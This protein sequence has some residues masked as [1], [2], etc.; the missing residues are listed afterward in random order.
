MH[1]GSGPDR[2]AMHARRAEAR[3][4]AVQLCLS[5]SAC[6]AHNQPHTNG[7]PSRALPRPTFTSEKLRGSLGGIHSPPRLIGT[8]TS[9]AAKPFYTVAGGHHHEKEA[10]S[11]GRVGGGRAS[12]HERKEN[13]QD[14]AAQGTQSGDARS[15]RISPRLWRIRPDGKRTQ[16]SGFEIGKCFCCYQCSFVPPCS[17]NALKSRR[18]LALEGRLHLPQAFMVR[19]LDT[20]EIAE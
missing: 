8:G 19:A 7:A 1:S 13:A 2:P 11:R 3:E 16:P 4:T 14:A 20:P 9:L 10:C 17:V 5:P 18:E 15:Q 12:V 6:A